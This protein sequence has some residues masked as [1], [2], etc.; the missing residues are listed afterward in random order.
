LPFGRKGRRFLIGAA[1]VLFLVVGVILGVAIPL[2]TNKDK[3]SLS[4]DSEVMPTQSPAPTKKPTQSPAPT[5]EPTQS[6]APTKEPT[7]SPSLDISTV[8]PTV[9]CPSPLLLLVDFEETLVIEYDVSDS[10]VY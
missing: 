6:P 4:I 10:P 2:T 1:L 7:Q 8:A 9:K 5:K 3:D